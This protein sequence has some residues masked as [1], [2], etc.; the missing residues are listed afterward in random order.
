M[1]DI[2]TKGSFTSTQWRELCKLSNMGPKYPN[3]SPTQSSAP[4]SGPQAKGKAKAKAK[5]SQMG[6]TASELPKSALKQ[7]DSRSRNTQYS[8]S[9]SSS[10]LLSMCLSIHS[11]LMYFE[12]SCPAP[13]VQAC[14]STFSELMPTSPG[15]KP[16]AQLRPNAKSQ[17]FGL[18]FLFRT[19]ASNFDVLF[20]GDFQN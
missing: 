17:S 2:M 4:S 1:A 14:A 18:R 7:R 12:S 13:L 8:T 9:S 3:K 10:G 6:A 20:N 19:L 16:R 5:P 11:G 15:K